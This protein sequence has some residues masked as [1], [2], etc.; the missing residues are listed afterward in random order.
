[1]EPDFDM[2]SALETISTDLNLG[3]G[4]DAGDD[5][6]PDLEV[7]LP[8]GEPAA[9]AEPKAPAEEPAAPTAEAPPAD[10]HV[11][12]PKTWRKEAAELWAHLDPKVRAEIHKRE[13]DIFRGI[14]EYRNDATFAR[15]V[16]QAL[17]QFDPL[18]KQYNIDTG[19]LLSTLAQTHFRIATATP[20]ARVQHFKQ[21]A[22]EYGIDAATLAPAAAVEDSPFIDPTVKALQDEL[23]G[24]KSALT[25]Q[26]QQRFES[27]KTDL[28]KDV[29]AFAADK[30]HPYFDEVSND[31]AA[32]LQ[33]GQAS[34]LKEAYEKAIYL[35]PVT[36]QKE[37]DRIA[38]E[39]IAAETAAKAAHAAAARK[40]TSANVRASAKS[41]S[42][43][44]P[45]GSI[46]DTLAQAHAAI[47]ARA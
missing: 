27:V 1:M 21:L 20:E 23:A 17:T 15:G 47:M 9:P 29:A 3:D 8:E 31:I 39:K 13:T 19:Q 36:R 22:K 25:R 30:A 18:I 10:E 44:A 26:E 14:E 2:D 5:G 16:R 45:L 38:G 6:L 12:P 4:G 46:D 41:G 7:K 43:T 40:A 35:N 24:I 11:A 37:I 42:G 32:L 34:S 28:Q 33:S